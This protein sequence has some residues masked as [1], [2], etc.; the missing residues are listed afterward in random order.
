MKKQQNI[1]FSRSGTSHQNGAAERAIKMA[2]AMARTILMH[3]ALRCPNDTFSIA[4]DYAIWVYNWV[5]D[6]Q[7]GLS[8]IEIW[9]RSSFE[10]VS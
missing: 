2:F 5:H 4:L 6:M 1:I 8:A 3:D 9:S 7:S 10:T